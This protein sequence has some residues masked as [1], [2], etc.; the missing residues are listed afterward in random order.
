YANGVKL[1]CSDTQLPGSPDPRETK[2]NGRGQRHDN[3]V[4]FLGEG[5]KWIFAN[6]SIITASDKKLLDEPLPPDAKRLYPST[7]HMANFLDCV[8]SRKPTICP[9]EVGYHSVVVCHIGN[10]ALRT[11]KQLKWDPVKEQFDDEAANKM[12]SRPM[13]SP[14]KLE[15]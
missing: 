6:R 2:V 8:K 4:L 10:I 1:V 12:L 3:G 15:A 9:A 14:Y 7:N 11:G 5:G 13:R